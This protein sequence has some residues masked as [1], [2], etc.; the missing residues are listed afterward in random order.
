LNGV[1]ERLQVIQGDAFDALKQLAQDKRRF[2]VVVIDPPALIKRKKDHAEGSLAYRRLAE[3][4]LKLVPQGGIL[5]MCSCSHHLSAIEL[6]E[7]MQRAAARLG[8]R[9]LVL[10]TLAQ[11]PDHPILASMPE[12][13]YLKGFLTL[14]D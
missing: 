7:L 9:L 1:A 10:K 8:R 14:V 12:T 13:A 2:G 4:G 5:I 11:S 3:A 6:L